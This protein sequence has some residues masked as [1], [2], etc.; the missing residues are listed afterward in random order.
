MYSVATGE[1]PSSDRGLIQVD[2][3]HP[4]PDFAERCC[5]A[6]PDIH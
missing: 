6:D 5:G 4:M 3:D 2:Y 1:L